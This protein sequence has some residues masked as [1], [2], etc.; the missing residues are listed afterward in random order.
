M[1]GVKDTLSCLE[2]GAVETLIVWENLDVNRFELMNSS[3]G[4]TITKMLSSQ[5]V[6][7]HNRM[8][9]HQGGVGN[10]FSTLGCLR[11][12]CGV[13]IVQSCFTSVPLEGGICLGKKICCHLSCCPGG[14][15][16]ANSMAVCA[17][18]G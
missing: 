13:V 14:A 6:L 7:L 17:G 12:L 16:W 11:F 8:W 1:F 3:S 2:M 5:Q 9:K 4:E 10:A 18:N 15:L